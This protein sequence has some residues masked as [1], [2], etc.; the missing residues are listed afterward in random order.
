MHN[1]N[2]RDSAPTKKSSFNKCRKTGKGSEHILGPS[3]D[4]ASFDA[5]E[6]FSLANEA[7]ADRA[8]S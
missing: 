4:L 5:T 6:W 2:A 8:A 1:A 7:K 3:E